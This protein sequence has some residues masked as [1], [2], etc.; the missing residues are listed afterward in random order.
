MVI[1]PCGVDLCGLVN[2]PKEGGE[3]GTHV[4]RDMKPV[5]SNRWE[6][7]IFDSATGRSY[8]SSINLK[9]DDLLQVEGCGSD[10]LCGG[11]NWARAKGQALQPS[12]R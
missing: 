7:R 5:A 6:G 1:R 2:W 9:A 12:R 3:L 8:A 10:F 11:Q 4:L